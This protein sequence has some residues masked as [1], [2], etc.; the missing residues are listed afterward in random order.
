[1]KSH[2]HLLPTLL[3]TLSALL[4]GSLLPLSNVLSQDGQPPA[5]PT[6]PRPMPLTAGPLRP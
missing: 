6:P 4:L 3:I 5:A 2:R 1:M